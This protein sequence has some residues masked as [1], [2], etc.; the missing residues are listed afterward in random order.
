MT[1]AAGSQKIFVS[2]YNSATIHNSETIGT[3]SEAIMWHLDTY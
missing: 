2:S 1:T 3:G